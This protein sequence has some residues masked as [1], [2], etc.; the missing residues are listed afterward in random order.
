VQSYELDFDAACY[1]GH[2]IFGD[3]PFNL[4]QVHGVACILAELM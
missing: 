1:G 3:G 2:S 4:A